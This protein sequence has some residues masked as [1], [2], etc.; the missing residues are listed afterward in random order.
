[1]RIRIRVVAV[2][3]LVILGAVATA[4]TV[5][6]VDPYAAFPS[7]TSYWANERGSTI[8]ID[9]AG[10]GKLSGRFTTAVGCGRGVAKPL[11]GFYNGNSVGFVVEFGRDCPSTTSWNGTFSSGT[12]NRLKTLWYLTSGGVPAW[13]STNAGSDNFTQITSAHA[14]PELR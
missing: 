10:G 1:M 12:P 7:G 6:T 11:A 2:T 9:N 5:R 3:V 14:P 8:R 13:N 4:Q